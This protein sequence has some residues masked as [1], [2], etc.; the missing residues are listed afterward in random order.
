VFLDSCLLTDTFCSEY[1]TLLFIPIS[2]SWALPEILFGVACRYVMVRVNHVL[3]S[4]AL[5]I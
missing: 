2:T 3:G 1:C 4:W 5:G